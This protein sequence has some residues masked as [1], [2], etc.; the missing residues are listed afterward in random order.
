[1][2]KLSQLHIK[3]QGK[4]SETIKIVQFKQMKSTCFH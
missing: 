2:R 3:S 1:M 4:L